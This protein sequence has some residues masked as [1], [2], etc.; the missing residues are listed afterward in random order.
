M[1]TK[2]KSLDIAY[3]QGLSVICV[4]GSYLVTLNDLTVLAPEALSIVRIM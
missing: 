2:R 3:I 1:G 4:M